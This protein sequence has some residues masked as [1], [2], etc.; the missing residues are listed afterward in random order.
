M[1]KKY[2]ILLI[3]FE[4]PPY[5]IGGIGSV[6]YEVTKAIK[7]DKHYISVIAPKD[8]RLFDLDVPYYP[9]PIRN[10]IYKMLV[11]LIKSIL[12][13][14]KNK[15]DFIYSLSGTYSGF[16]ALVIS[17]IFRIKY[18]TVAHGSEFIRFNKNKIIKMLIRSV[19]NNSSKVFS[20][21]TFTKN[22][23]VEFGVNPDKIFVSYNGVNTQ[24]YFPVSKEEKNRFR[25]KIGLKEDKFILL[26]ISRLDKRKG[27]INTIRALNEIFS[28][29][30]DLKDKIV[31]LIGGKGSN[32]NMINSF[33]EENNLMDNVKLL[34]FVE[35]NKINHYYNISDLFIQPNIYLEEQGNVEGFG[36]VFLEAAA[37][38]KTSIGGIAGGSTEAIKD[39]ETG[40]IVDGENVDD[41]KDKIL[42][43]LF[44]PD[45]L[46]KLSANAY[47]NAVTNFNWKKIVN[48]ILTQIEFCLNLK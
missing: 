15:P 7:N 2:N 4:M 13:V 34:G 39:G 36:L 30:K 35:E 19:F 43:L 42:E 21:S 29:K 6:A 18:F 11:M 45:K 22:R 20:V 10:N 25:N 40:F 44:E 12:F 38:G 16:V 41:I 31:Y 47:N 24:S 48:D 1:N 17:R 32:Y 27:H 23:L 9:I 33:I 8:K 3:S 5:V 46:D 26:T 28:E 37:A 14:L